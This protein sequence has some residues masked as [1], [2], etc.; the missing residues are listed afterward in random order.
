[1]LH[2]VKRTRYSL[3][4]PGVSSL[5]L[6][7]PHEA[8]PLLVHLVQLARPARLRVLLVDLDGGVVLADRLVEPAERAVD[9]AEVVVEDRLLGG[10]LDR[11][12]EALDRPTR[13][14]RGECLARLALGGRLP[15]SPYT[16]GTATNLSSPFR[17]YIWTA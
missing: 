6:P 5:T 2:A 7:A 16:S 4:C 12:L 1:M 10:E 17:A 13:L 8:Q 3:P 15:V 9:V 11:A 14:A